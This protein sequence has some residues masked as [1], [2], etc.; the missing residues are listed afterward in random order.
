MKLYLVPV[1]DPANKGGD[2]GDFGFS[3]SNS[4]WVRIDQNW[5]R[6]DCWVRIGQHWVKI[7]QFKIG[8]SLV[9]IIRLAFTCANEKSKVRLQ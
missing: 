2:E 8:Q 7:G 6:I 9:P 5:V 3:T 4:L 1:H